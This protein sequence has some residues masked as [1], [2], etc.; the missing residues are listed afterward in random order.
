MKAAGHEMNGLISYY[1][2]LHGTELKIPL[3][4]LIDYR[5]Y[6]LTAI[7]LLPIAKET[8]VYGSHDAAETIHCSEEVSG[9][10]KKLGEEMNIKG[11]IVGVKNKA[12]IYGPADI[13]GK[14][15]LNFL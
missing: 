10:M 3:M 11:H 8:I 6:R 13:E 7:S 9:W 12:T 5:G 15:L 2:H 4:A 1:N 14:F